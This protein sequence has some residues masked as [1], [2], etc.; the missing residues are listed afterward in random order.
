[1]LAAIDP[2]N[3]FRAYGISP[4]EIA[5]V[6]IMPRRIDVSRALAGQLHR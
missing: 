5:R 2:F 3:G 6:I 1:V 4:I